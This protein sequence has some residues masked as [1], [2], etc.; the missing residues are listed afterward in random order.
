MTDVR[1]VVSQSVHKHDWFKSRRMANLL[2]ARCLGVFSSS[3]HSMFT[4][5]YLTCHVPHRSSLRASRANFGKRKRV[6]SNKKLVVDL[7]AVLLELQ[8]SSNTSL[9]MLSEVETWRALCVRA[10]STS[11]GQPYAAVRGGHIHLYCHERF[12]T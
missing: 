12:R 5:L 1:N 2:R 9:L 4:D 10:G 8:V 11:D 3:R 6:L 7:Q